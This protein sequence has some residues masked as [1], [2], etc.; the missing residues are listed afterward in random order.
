MVL[1]LVLVGCKATATVAVVVEPNGS[2]SVSITAALDAD[3]AARVGTDL[4]T[5]IRTEDLVAAGWTVGPLQ[6]DDGQTSIAASKAFATADG[7]G[8]ILTDIGGPDGPFVGWDLKTSDTFTAAG[9]E[10]D[11]QLKLTGSLDQFSDAEVAAALD[12][13]ALGRSPEE[14]AAD[15]ADGSSLQLGIDVSLPGDIDEAT[16]LTVAEGDASGA[17]RLSRTFVLGDGSAVD[18]AVRVSATASDRSAVLWIVLGAALV[19]GALLLVVARQR[20]RRRRRRRPA[21]IA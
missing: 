11:G 20:V 12:G 16:G 15:L 8:P 7:L 2:G 14:L 10:L 4:A 18:E 3:A 5:A 21:P 17:G 9:Y 13:F 1:A 6:T 19:V